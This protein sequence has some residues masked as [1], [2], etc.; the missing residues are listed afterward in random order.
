MKQQII[1]KILLLTIFSI[2]P[3]SYC[4]YAQIPAGIANSNVLTF[5]EYWT[6]KAK[7]HMDFKS[8][9]WWRYKIYETK[10]FIHWMLP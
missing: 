6:A 5:Q 7:D 2:N 3:N 8:G 9:T 10:K 4:K 1:S